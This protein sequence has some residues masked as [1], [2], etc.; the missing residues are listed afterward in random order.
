MSLLEIC[1]KS[2]WA[3]PWIFLSFYMK[4]V[5]FRFWKQWMEIQLKFR[6]YYLCIY[7]ADKKNLSIHYFL[8]CY[9]FC[10]SCGVWVLV[11]GPLTFMIWLSYTCVVVNFDL[12]HESSWAFPW[13]LLSFATSFLE[14]CHETS[15]VFPWD[16]FSFAMS[17]LVLCHESSW[18]LPWV[19]LSVPW[20][21]LSFYMKDVGFRF[22][23]QWME[24]QLKFRFYYL[25]IYYADKKNL[26][27]HYF[28]CCYSFC[29]SYGVWVLVIG[30]LT[31]MIWLS[32]TCVVVN[33]ELCHESSW[34]FTWRM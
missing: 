10:F 20:I 19:F 1:H 3:L 15:W 28:L 18:D 29:F 4:D 33:F 5:G 31:L 22:W 24:I 30:P 8:C 16:F 32:Y 23:K 21:F 17:L 12:C 27:I 6:F 34:V 25:C 7:Y 14:L 11:I 9:S 2:S 13:V 26:C